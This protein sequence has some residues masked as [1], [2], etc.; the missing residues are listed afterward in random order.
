VVGG[1]GE[2]YRFI[3]DNLHLFTRLSMRLY[4]KGEKLR[5][6]GIKDWREQ[7]LTIGGVDAK[8]RAFV[9]IQADPRFKTKEERAAEFVR[10]DLGSRSTYFALKKKMPSRAV[11][12]DPI[13]I[14]RMPDPGTDA[15]VAGGDE[16]LGLTG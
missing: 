11:I 1:A 3:G 5:K 4:G 10:R 13:K 16:A 2:V 15:T 7:L 6:A 9:A 8:T 12:L 14:V